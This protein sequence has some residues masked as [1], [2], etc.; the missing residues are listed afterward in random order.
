MDIVWCVR[1]LSYPLGHFSLRK[2]SLVP[3]CR[4]RHST[5]PFTKNKL[6]LFKPKS[7]KINPCLFVSMVYLQ[8][9][10][11]TIYFTVSLPFLLRGPLRSKCLLSRTDSLKIETDNMNRYSI[12]MSY[13]K[14][15]D[16]VIS[17]FILYT[18]YDSVG[19]KKR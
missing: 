10:Y 8:C 11:E 14:V 3:V 6:T 7:D 18:F 15:L 13:T 5:V 19:L 9:L 17:P 1:K 16:T 12:S 2:K 4:Y